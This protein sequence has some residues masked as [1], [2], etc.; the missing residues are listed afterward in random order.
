[1]P[2]MIAAWHGMTEFVKLLCED[3]RT[4]LNQQD[5]NGFSAL[6]KACMNGYFWEDLSRT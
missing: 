1:M 6:M 3:E 4:S 2:L 5:A